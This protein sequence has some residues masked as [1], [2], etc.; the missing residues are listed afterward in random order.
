MKGV[1][2]D[3]D[4][5][6]NYF[7]KGCIFGNAEACMN[8]GQLFAGFE[9]AISKNF[10]ISIFKAMYFLDKACKG[11]IADACRNASIIAYRG[12]HGY[13]VDEK[14]ALAFARKACH[15]NNGPSCKDVSLMYEKGIGTEKNAKLAKR[16]YD[17][18]IDIRDQ[19]ERGQVIETQRT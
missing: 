5:A 13:P 12:R 11:D 18:F 19:Y 6:A 7:Q 17:K 4:R 16:Y 1:Q 8:A 2:R 10:K 15:L 14:K 9:T 3:A